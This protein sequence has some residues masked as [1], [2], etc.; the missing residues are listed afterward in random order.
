MKKINQPT[1][2]E[3]EQTITDEK[4]QVRSEEEIRQAIKDS[5]VLYLSLSGGWGQ[6]RHWIKQWEKNNKKIDEAPH[7]QDSW[8]H[9]PLLCR[10]NF[11][12]RFTSPDFYYNLQ[13]F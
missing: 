4:N 10:N 6:T 12:I 9:M 5:K 13:M 11:R 7:W 3:E 8:I 1:T 2:K